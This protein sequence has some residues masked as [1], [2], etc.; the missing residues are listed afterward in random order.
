VSL[1]A[2]STRYLVL[3]PGMTGADGI[4]ELSRLVVR[5]ISPSGTEPDSARVDVLSLT[6]PPGFRAGDQDGS[7][8][9]F[10][11]AGG[12]R[13][14]LVAAAARAGLGRARAAEILCLHLH[15]SPVARL[16]AAR[17]VPLVTLLVGIEA[18]KPLGRAQRLAVKRSDLLVAISA[19][20]ARRFQEAN[21]DFQDRSVRICHLAVRDRDGASVG[22]ESGERVARPWP[23]PF[24]LIVGRM[25]AEERYKGH[26]LL[27]DIWPS[28]MDEVPGARLV[29]VGDGDDRA[30][31]EAR[32]AHIKDHVSF[33]G[34]VSDGVLAGLY[35][36]CA[37]FVMPSRD[38]GFGLVF[39]E[40]MRKG[41][42]CIGGVGAAAELIENGVTGLV[43]EQDREQLLRAMVRLFREP[44]TRQRMGEAG[45][46]RVAREFTEAHFRH[47]FRAL[48]W[49]AP[50]A[51]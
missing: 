39:L 37:F 15:L 33:L 6:D 42:A 27:I 24:A 8:V 20:T 10:F 1:R 47:R 18:W 25:A 14:R 26:D 22:L 9:R 29:V 19:H 5:A 49:L 34:R 40:A 48:L 32:A 4:A 12:R 7:G 38:E 17:R 16:I 30:R 41:K 51:A 23:G 36:E 2:V 13:F 45:A 43:V 46:A 35:R 50:G 44:E 28:V 11:G 3:T 21:P 31:L